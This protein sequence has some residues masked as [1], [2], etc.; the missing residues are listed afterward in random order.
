VGI[1][2]DLAINERIFDK[3]VR[4]IDEKGAQL[5]VMSKADAQRIA[6]FRNL[7]LVNI[8]PTAK[9]PVCKI[10]DYGKY[11][12]EMQKKEKEQKKAQKIVLLK[13][14]KLSQTID[15]G[16]INTKAR[17][18]RGFLEEGNKVKVSIRMA[19]RQ[20]AHPEVSANVLDRFFDILKDIAVVEKKPSTEG[21]VMF[22]ILTSS[23]KKV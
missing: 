10:M 13:E 18:A 7:D 15:V 12:F 5:G 8:S 16:D 20:N 23:T 22:M 3:E 21:K 14:V 2:K 4:L 11:R 19:G 17:Q 9:P 1:F 6:D